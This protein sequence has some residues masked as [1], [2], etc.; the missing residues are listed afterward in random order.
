MRR[1]DNQHVCVFPDQPPSG[2]A[3]PRSLSRR[4]V[5]VATLLA[6]GKSAPAIAA[7]LHISPS[8]A[9]VHRRKLMRKLDPHSVVDLS[10]YAIRQGLVLP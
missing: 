3:A 2:E 10:K 7:E 6:A 4:E 8:T 1:I 9:D 5:Q